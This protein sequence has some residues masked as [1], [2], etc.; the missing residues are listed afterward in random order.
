V[1]AVASQLSG[2]KFV[3]RTDVKSY[4][5]S[6]DHQALLDRLT[7]LIGDRRVLALPRRPKSGDFGYETN[8]PS[9]G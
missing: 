9:F 5:A 2:N 1:R 3:F 8:S 7:Q 6:I 4:Y